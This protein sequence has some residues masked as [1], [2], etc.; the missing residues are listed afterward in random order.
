M[1]KVLGL[2]GKKWE[3][4]TTSFIAPLFRLGMDKRKGR[5]SGHIIADARPKG[6]TPYAVTL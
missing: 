3:S 2:S 1:L 5:V 6:T 4:V